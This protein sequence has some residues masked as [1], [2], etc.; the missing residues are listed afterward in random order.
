MHTFSFYLL[1]PKPS[2]PMAGSQRTLLLVICFLCLGCIFQ[3]A[4]EGNQLLKK[5]GPVLAT[6]PSTTRRT[7]RSEA[8]GP[9][10][11]R[12]DNFS[13]QHDAERVKED[14]ARKRMEGNH[15]HGVVRRVNDDPTRDAMSKLQLLLPTFP[16]GYG[17]LQ[18]TF[19][20]SF[21][22]FWPREYRNVHVL[23]DEISLLDE[24]GHHSQT[25]EQ[26]NAKI[27]SFFEKEENNTSNVTDFVSVSYNPNAPKS[28]FGERSG[29]FMQQLIMLWADNFTD[30]EFIGFCD[31]DMLL[32]SVTQPED[33]FDEQGRPHVIVKYP[34]HAI[35]Q[36]AWT[37]NFLR[38]SGRA[39]QSTRAISMA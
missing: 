2:A 5:P 35:E 31:D 20:R 16:G 7:P 11:T 30:S 33:L 12:E 4:R 34:T 32:T 3:G 17:E 37:K 13:M 21:L 26:M 19:I 10:R 28:F 1:K 36:F 18:S 15:D 23:L 25:K 22:F 39:F 6:N 9:S 8:A 27:L 14:S 29:W 38:H 24:E